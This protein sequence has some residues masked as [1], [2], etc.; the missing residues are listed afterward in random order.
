MKEVAD[1]FPGD[2]PLASR[3]TSLYRSLATMDAKNTATAVALARLEL[4]SDPRDRETLAKIGDI[5]ADHDRLAAARPWWDAMPSTAPGSVNAWR[6]SAT[7]FWDYFLFD[8]ALR[9]IRNARTRLHNPALLAYEA[10]AIYEG[11]GRETQAVAE[12]LNGYLSGD[13]RRNGGS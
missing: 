1:A 13:N 2:R 9:V 12:Y 7:V 6:D 8:D 3:A 4:Q 11:K 10:G 5:Y